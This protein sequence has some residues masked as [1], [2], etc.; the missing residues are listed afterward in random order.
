MAETSEQNAQSRAIAEEQEFVSYAYQALDKQ[1]QYYDEQLRKVR[2]Q[3]GRGTP[4]KSL[5]AIRSLH[6]TRTIL[7]DY[8]MSKI[9]WF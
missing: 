9:D 8:A 6:I 4:A 7:L 1:R 3:G 5:N 2:A